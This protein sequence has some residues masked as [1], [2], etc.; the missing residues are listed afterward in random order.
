M[1]LCTDGTSVY[2]FIRNIFFFWGGGGGGGG[3]MESEPMLTPREKTLYQKNSS[4]RRVEP[5]TL[6][7]RGQRAQH[8]TNQLLQPSKLSSGRIT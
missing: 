6:H 5:T 7:Q 3:R 8:T 2:T 1:H 4:Q